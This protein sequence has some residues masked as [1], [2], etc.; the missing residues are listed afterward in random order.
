MKGIKRDETD[1][2]DSLIE[3]AA[4]AAGVSLIE[5]Q[6]KFVVRLRK[7]MNNATSNSAKESVCADI[8]GKYIVP[9]LQWLL[10]PFS[11]EESIES[12]GRFRVVDDI[13]WL[14]TAVNN[15]TMDF[16]EYLIKTNTAGGY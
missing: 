5:I 15:S 13:I 11:S 12:T 7:L 3:S 2:L 4:T 6:I 9:M 8:A 1:T 10:Y 14:L 16:T